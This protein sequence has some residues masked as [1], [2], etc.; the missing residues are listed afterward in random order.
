MMLRPIVLMADEILKTPTLEQKWG[1]KARSYLELAS[2]MFQKWDS[3]NCWRANS[4][5]GVWI[6][7]GFGIDL[8]S[9]KWSTGFERRKTEG[10][11]NPA[12]KQ[13]HIARWM[14]AMYDATEKEVD[15][16]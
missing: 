13:N 2:Q 8:Q 7:P 10:F 9:G 5:G 12:N 1:T 16:E 4:V 3:R 6:V 14:V 15:R 11:S